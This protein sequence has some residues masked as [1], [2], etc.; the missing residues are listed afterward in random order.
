[1]TDAQLEQY[2]PVARST[3]KPQ[4]WLS[5]ADAIQAIRAA[6]AAAEDEFVTFN[7]GGGAG[8]I[9]VADVDVPTLANCLRALA[10]APQAQPDAVT[11]P[12]A[13]AESLLGFADSMLTLTRQP[14]SVQILRDA[15]AAPQAQPQVTEA[16][17][18]AAEGFFTAYNAR[19]LARRTLEAALAAT[20]QA[21]PQKRHKRPL[22]RC[23]ANRDGD[24]CHPDC[25]Q[26]RDGE[27]KKSGRDC[28]LD[29]P[30][31]Y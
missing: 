10:G 6:L 24:C 18:D 16:M 3:G 19:D 20:P 11:I 1:M 28:P 13:T 5:K 21:Q 7:L 17:V 27:P 23:A 31:E 8:C 15:L 22:T 2:L 9:K 25:P 4:V 14:A 30:R 12:R 26:V 29:Y